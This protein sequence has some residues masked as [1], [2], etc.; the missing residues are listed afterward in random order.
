[1]AKH[2]RN[3]LNTRSILTLREQV[4]EHPLMMCRVLAMAIYVLAHLALTAQCLIPTCLWRRDHGCL[5]FAA[6][7]PLT[8]ATTE[9]TSTAVYLTDV[10]GLDSSKIRSLEDTLEIDVLKQ[11]AEW[12]QLRLGLV[13]SELNKLVRELPQLLYMPKL[14]ERLDFLQARLRRDNASFKKTVL[15]APKILLLG[16]KGDVAPA[17]DW[18]QQRL[19][20]TDQQ[21]NRIIKSVP[22]IVNLVCENRDAISTKLDWLQ[23]TLGVENERLGFILC[24]VPTFITMSDESLEPKIRWLKRRLS[25]SK[26][27]A[28]SL[29]R[30]NPSLLAS[31]IEFNLQPK[32]NF[33]DSVLGEEEAVKLIQAEPVV[34]SCSMKRRYEPRLSDARRVGL[35]I[36]ASL[37][38]KMG[39]YNEKQW[40]TVL[41]NCAPEK[42]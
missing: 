37:I 22:A 33:F 12:L 16:V 35:D 4:I 15:R 3:G 2:G 13:D 34:L 1:M 14:G 32:L 18:L 23:D 20:L 5:Q 9:N 21:L 38:R 36:D 41:Q 11:Q 6:T 10:L 25:I 31:S 26:D 29:I 17:L 30:E 24:H 28:L 19:V 42:T 39:M 40:Q 8:Y 27:E 7:S